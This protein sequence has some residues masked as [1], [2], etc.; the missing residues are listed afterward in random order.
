MKVLRNDSFNV[1]KKVVGTTKNKILYKE[2]TKWV[3][4]LC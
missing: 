4:L 2:A 1:W 3:L